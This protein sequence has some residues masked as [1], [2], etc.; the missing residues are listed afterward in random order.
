MVL[1][2]APGRRGGDRGAP[3][4]GAGHARRLPR[5]PC[6]TACSRVRSGTATR[7]ASSSTTP[8]ERRTSGVR[9]GSLPRAWRRRRHVLRDLKPDCS[10]SMRRGA[11]PHRGLSTTGEMAGASRR[12]TAG[13]RYRPIVATPPPSRTSRPPAACRARS[14]AACHAV[15]HEVKDRAPGHRDRTPRVMREHEHR[16]VSGLS[17][18]PNPGPRSRRATVRAHRAEHAAPGAA[19][20]SGRRLRYPIVASIDAATMPVQIAIP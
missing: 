9:A 14:S 19:A 3:A 10:R 12:P 15:G 17:P 7:W 20:A 5:E 4:A 8:L 2:L 1:P 13:C 11:A 18:S 16:H 6:G